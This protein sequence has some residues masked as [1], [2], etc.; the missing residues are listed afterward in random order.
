MFPFDVDCNKEYSLV[1]IPTSGEGLQ[2]TRLL[3]TK[4]TC[5]PMR[6]MVLDNVEANQGAP[7][8]PHVLVHTTHGAQVHG[9]NVVAGIRAP[10]NLQKKY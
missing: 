1:Q 8:R 2:R 6:E 9:Q 7:H 5:H 10:L 4:L 3:S